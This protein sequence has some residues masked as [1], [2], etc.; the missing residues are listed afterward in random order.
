V[1]PERASPVR[2]GDD[3]RTNRECFVT[4]AHAT[5]NDALVEILLG[6]RAAP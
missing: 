1:E 3:A 5:H 4:S 2:P 6:E